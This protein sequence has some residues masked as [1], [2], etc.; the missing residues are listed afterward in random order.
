MIRQARSE[1]FISYFVVR[2]DASSVAGFALMLDAADRG[3]QV[4]IMLDGL[5]RD[6]AKP[7]LKALVSH[8]NIE[9]RDYNRFSIFSLLRAFRRSHEKLILADNIHS[10]SY[11]YITGGRNISNKYFGYGTKRNFHDIDVYVHGESALVAR[12]EFFL[13]Q[14]ESEQ[15][16]EVPLGNYSPENLELKTCPQAKRE[17]DQCNIDLAARK[18]TYEK[19][20]QRIAE[21]TLPARTADIHHLRQAL[22]NQEAVGHVGKTTAGEYHFGIQ[23][24]HGLIVDTVGQRLDRRSRISGQIVADHGQV[25]RPLKVRPIFSPAFL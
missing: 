11:H 2:D 16:Q 17:I 19:V 25:D 15:V 1:L 13:P 18:R 6:I 12:N 3:V 7:Y 8:P 22:L 4:K 21:Q 9:V 10:G 14:W 20:L 5:F 23:R 24:L